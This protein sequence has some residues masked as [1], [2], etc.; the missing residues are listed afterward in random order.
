[1]H[2]YIVGNGRSKKAKLVVW[3]SIVQWLS[4]KRPKKHAFPLAE[5]LWYLDKKA[6]LSWSI[7]KTCDAFERQHKL[8]WTKATAQDELNDQPATISIQQTIQNLKELNAC[9]EANA[10]TFSEAEIT[11]MQGLTSK[12]QPPICKF[13]AQYPSLISLACCKTIIRESSRSISGFFQFFEILGV[14]N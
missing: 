5:K 8:P 4:Q 7:Q 11:F 2:M 14:L 6:E 3:F 10:G 9:L 1:M 13:R 12:T